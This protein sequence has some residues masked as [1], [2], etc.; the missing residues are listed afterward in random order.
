MEEDD[1]ALTPSGESERL[2]QDFVRSVHESGPIEVLEAADRYGTAIGL[3]KITVHL[4]DL[5][6]RLLVP[7]TGGPILEGLIGRGVI[8]HVKI[9]AQRRSRRRQREVA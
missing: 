2:F 3:G 7:L 1:E 5:Q 4:A 9:S 6:Q 8:D